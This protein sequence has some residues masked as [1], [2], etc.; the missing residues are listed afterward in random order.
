MDN[1]PE[2]SDPSGS[3]LRVDD[4]NGDGLA[5]LVQVGFN[6]IEIW[7][8]VDGTSWTAE[9]IISNAPAEPSYLNRVRLVDVNGS[10]TRG[11]IWGDGGAYKYMDLSGGRQPWLLTHV[12]NGLGKTSDFQYSNSTQLMLAAEAAGQPWTSKSP[13]PMT[14]ITQVTES[15]HLDVIGLPPGNYVTQFT[16]RDPVYDGRQREFRGFRT[17][18]ERKVG[19]ANSPSST[20]TQTFLLGECVN[21]E[22]VSPDPCT[23]AGRWEDNPREALK[24]LPLA[25]DTFDDNGVYLS[26]KHTTYR[27]RKLYAGLDGRE[28]RVAFPSGSD[29]FLYDTGAFTPAASTTSVT[30]VELETTLGTVSPD[31][32]SALT[33]RATAGRAHLQTNSVVDPFGNATDVI[34]AGCVDGCASVDQSIIGSASDE[35]ITKHATP[36]RRT[37]CDNSG[38]MWRTVES[39]VTGSFTSG[40]LDDHLVQYDCGGSPTQT[41]GVLQ[42]TLPLDR[43]HEMGLPVAQVP[44]Q[45]SQDGPIL[46][47]AMVYDTFGVLVQSSASNGRCHSTV[48][49]GSFDELPIVETEYVGTAG[50]DGCGQTALP[51]TVQD[52]DRGFG[53]IKQVT[54]PNGELTTATY[55]GFGRMASLSK[56]DPAAVGSSSAFPGVQIEYILPT[57]AATTPYSVVLTNLLTDIQNGSNGSQPT[58][59]QTLATIDGLGRPILNADQADP[60]AGDGGPWIVEKL[61]THDG[62]G[63]VAVAYQPWFAAQTPPSPPVAPPTAYSHARFDAFGRAL[64]TY[65]IDGALSLRSVYHALS[66]DHW[67]AADLQAGGAHQGTFASEVKDGHGRPII[68]TE[69]LHNGTSIEA[70]DT[71]TQFRP[72]G[73]PLVISRVR[74]NAPDAPVVRWLQY[75]SLGRIVLNMEPDT[76]AGYVG[77]PTTFGATPAA[78]PNTTHAWRYAYDNNGDLV[79][80][81]DA[82]GCGA[83]YHYDAGGRIVAEDFSPCLASQQL[84]SQPDLSTGD[85]TEAFYQYDDYTGIDLPQSNAPGFPPAGLARGHLVSTSDRGART[86][87]SYD[88]RGRT[89]AVARLVAGPGGPSDTL[90]DRYDPTWSI[91]N[92]TYDEA[93]RPLTTATGADV[94]ELLPNGNPT[95]AVATQ[96]SARGSIRSVTS[97]YG[98]L[99]SSVTRDADGLVNQVVYGDTAGTTSAFTY[100]VRRRLASVQTYRGPPA[101]WS[102]TPPA[103]LPA[104]DPGGSPSTFQLLLEDADYHYDVVD[105]PVEID[106]W[107]IPSEWPAG[108]Q[109]VSRK[110]Q[111]DDLY[112]TTRVDY[113]YP[114]AGTDPWTSP[115]D[116]EDTNEATDPRL[117]KPSTHVSFTNRVLRQTFQYDWLGNTTVTD[118]DAH[119]FYDRSLGVATNGAA[120]AGPYQLQGAAGADPTRGGS[121]TTVYDADGNLGSLAINRGGPCLPSGSNCTQR[122]VYDWDEVGR[123]V[124]ARRWDLGSP[125]AATD[126]APSGP[127]AAD[128]AYS[129]DSNDGRVL[130][131]ASDGSGNRQAT[132]YIFSSL[133]LR[134]AA[135]DGT[136]WTRDASTEVVYLEAHGVRL[137][138]VQAAIE[139]IPSENGLSPHVLLEMPDHLGSTS[140]VIDRDTSEL[141]ERGTYMA[142]GQADSDYRSARWGYFR[143]DYRFT[144]KEEDVEVGLQYFGKRYYAP[145]LERWVSPDPLTVHEL[146]SDLNA[147]AYVHGGP[148]KAVDPL[149]LAENGN[150]SYVGTDEPASDPVAQGMSSQDYQQKPVEGAPPPSC[151]VCTECSVNGEAA[152]PDGAG[153]QSVD[154]LHNEVRWNPNAKN[155]TDAMLLG[156]KSPATLKDTDPQLYAKLQQIAT[157]TKRAAKIVW[158]VAQVAQPELMAV[159]AVITIA[160]PDATAGEKTLAVVSVIPFGRLAELASAAADGKVLTEGIKEYDVLRYGDKAAGLEKHHG[161]MD[162]WATENVDGY[163]SRGDNTPAIALSKDNHGA[164]K[165]VFRDWLEGQ[166]GKRVGGSV[167]WKAV[168]PQEIQTLTE[169][170]FDAAKVPAEARAAYYRAFNQYIYNVK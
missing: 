150:S 107:R 4:V 95:S 117:G 160:D 155:P 149:G 68:T 153:A 90:S 103:Y 15:D 116:A 137:A 53:V 126:A 135:D 57:N 35:V 78:I 165:A 77:P 112:R 100:D 141:V 154:T 148:L 24:G 37:D 18:S 51:T 12:A 129:Y 104:P 123:L 125:V 91:R 64:E 69:R 94:S 105:N 157:D 36:G 134:E 106:D 143:E 152:T 162:K 55:D 101:L 8:N 167:D 27:L 46:L 67:D 138:R 93:D 32:T 31:T 25:S 28:V 170:M 56:P 3:N 109:P 151:Q 147:Y 30:D 102:Q 111:Y 88:G 92:F 133:E 120:G 2:F 81:S 163:V 122:F 161:V 84:Y 33:L 72:T 52:Y 110:I 54:D 58:Y 119:G 43:H 74:V 14:V 136:R 45:A 47:S 124:R 26:T 118:D 114:G 145:G 44:P 63:A 142:Y 29:S 97:S 40:V 96:Y 164:T 156:S 66:A 9:H 65:N 121:L 70:H 34:D 86:V 128:L 80:T 89:V 82:R 79:G 42:G 139:A 60:A 87:T 158:E 20:S 1:A 108:A 39:S 76:T 10:G 50:S 168:S 130:K 115:F 21:D 22:N 169:K 144:G 159:Q 62:K 113:V 140:I 98:P 17:A 99:V 7:L 146:G 13:M 166:T 49:D 132:V 71:R 16:Y 127:T 59:R 5:D 73:Q 6:D 41:T 19:D 48:S 61:T 11:I 75:D 85:K 131:V 83:N 38:W 23:P